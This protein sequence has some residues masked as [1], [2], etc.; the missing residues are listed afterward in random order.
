MQMLKFCGFLILAALSVSCGTQTSSSVNISM[1]ENMNSI[2][3]GTTADENEFPFVVN[4]WINS[5]K[6]NYV[7]HLCG[8]TLIDKKWVLTAAHC[9]MEDYTESEMRVMSPTKLTLYIGSPHHS[10]AGGRKISARSIQ[11]H[12]K[13]S[14]PN[15]DVALVELAEA[16]TDVAPVALN[17]K[18]LGES[19]EAATV[20]GWGLTD[21]AGKNEA[22][23]LQ[24]VTLS[25]EPRKLCTN[26]GLPRNNNATIGADMLCAQTLHHQKS[27]CPGD[28]GGPLLQFADERFVQIGIV[29][30]SSACSGNRHKYESSVAGY[31]DVSDALEWI[32]KVIAK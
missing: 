23:L 8:A 12:P 24:K 9:M 29:S 17:E 19:T 2:I 31:A 22:P 27:S 26:D 30:W 21:A 15:H 3:G 4:I 1:S 18:D 20:I 28:S 14:W 11:V 32:R 6:D 7:A 10:G 16:V 25:L 13:Y 5:P